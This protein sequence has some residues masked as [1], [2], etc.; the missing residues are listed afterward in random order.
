[1]VQDRQDADVWKKIVTSYK[2]G[3]IFQARVSAVGRASKDGGTPAPELVLWI[4]RVKGVIPYEHSSLPSPEDARDI[5]GQIVAFVVTGLDEDKRTFTASRREAL[6]RM[7]AATWESI[8]P[9]QV[10]AACVRAVTRYRA[11]VDIGGVT[12]AIPAKEVSYYWVDDVRDFLSIEN[13]LDV[14]VLEVDRDNRRISVSLRAIQPDPWDDEPEKLPYVDQRVLGTIAAV[15]PKGDRLSLRINIEP[16]FVCFTSIRRNGY[17][18]HA[19]GDRVL[20]RLR[21]VKPEKKFILASVIEQRNRDY[22]PAV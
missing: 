18:R 11:I 16:G 19:K 9:G 17:V 14:K 6:E 13:V 21:D 22:S 15:T 3:T 1:M 10:R 7:A 2:K 20:V 8:Q 4:D 5:V 12:C